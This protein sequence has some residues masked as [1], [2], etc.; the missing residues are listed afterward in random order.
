MMDSWPIAHELEKQYPSPSLHLDDPIVVRVR[1]D[2]VKV[3]GPLGPQLYPK[4]PRRILNKESADYFERTREVRFGMP[5]EQLEK[6]KGTEQNWVDVKEPAEE[7]AA[8]LKKNGGPFF[9]G[10]T[11]ES[12]IDGW[13]MRD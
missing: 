1:D 8:L 3:F 7:M 9:L 13:K 10:N 2:I 6:E 5:L 12:A 11:G 4:V